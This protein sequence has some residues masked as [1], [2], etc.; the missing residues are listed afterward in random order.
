MKRTVLHCLTYAVFLFVI[1]DYDSLFLRSA[2]SGMPTRSSRA[3]SSAFAFVCR[4]SP[5]Q[6]LTR[7]YFQVCPSDVYA[8]F[9]PDLERMGDLSVTT[10]KAMGENA[11]A[12]LPYVQVRPNPSH[13]QKPV[14]FFA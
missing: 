1:F 14:Y 12:N 3:G 5:S 7:F 6:S 10:Y 9:S 11:D 13:S 2:T 4:R 8:G